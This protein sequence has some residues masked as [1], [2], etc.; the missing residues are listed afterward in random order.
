MCVY[1][2]EAGSIPHTLL[3]SHPIDHLNDVRNVSQYLSR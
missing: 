2:G 3:E 1:G